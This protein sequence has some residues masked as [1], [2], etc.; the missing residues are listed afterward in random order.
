M[1]RKKRGKQKPH[2][3]E[4]EPR[5]VSEIEKA[6]LS[7]SDKIQIIMAILTGF[8]LIGVGI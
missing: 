7:I 4:K 1:P 6:T 5:G 2:N 3:N 8:S